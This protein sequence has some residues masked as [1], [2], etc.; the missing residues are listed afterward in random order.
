MEE[1]F[2]SSL[3][4]CQ[5]IVENTLINKAAAKLPPTLSE[6]RL[7]STQKSEHMA[8]MILKINKHPYDRPAN[9]LSEDL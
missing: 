2:S 6:L 8:D 9:R 7:Y 4:V 3:H 1:R 5:F